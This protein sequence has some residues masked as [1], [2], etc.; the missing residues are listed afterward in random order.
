M[1]DFTKI[2]IGSRTYN[3][4]DAWARDI[5]NKL[6]KHRYIFVADSYG[7]YPTATTGWLKLVKDYCAL[8]GSDVYTAA[9]SGA[10]FGGPS[11]GTF[12]T[13]L[14][15]IASSVTSKNT[16]TDI[17]VCGGINDKMYAAGIDNGISLFMAYAA[18]H[19]PNAKVHVGFISKT[20][21]PDYMWDT[22]TTVLDHY[23]AVSSYSNAC[24]MKDSEYILH[25]YSYLSSSD[26]DGTHPSAAGSQIIA[27]GIANYI[28]TGSCDVRCEFANNVFAKASGITSGQLGINQTFNNGVYCMHADITT[29]TFPATSSSNLLLGTIANPDLIYGQST[30]ITFAVDCDISY[31]S[32]Q[33]VHDTLPFYISGGKLY[34]NV[35][36]SNVTQITTYPINLTI[37]YYLN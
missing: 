5:I 22:Y 10:G 31:G 34:V 7:N 36:Y 28:K 30:Y 18:E 37:P 8:S 6:V 24:Y 35:R 20:K 12:L 15:S 23:K 17:V 13:A 14:Q 25:N 2:K 11:G 26:P 27:Q 16:I 4:A 21:T 32:N 9:L 1:A 3:V 33:F 19:Y 29:F